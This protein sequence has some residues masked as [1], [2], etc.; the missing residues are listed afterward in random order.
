MKNSIKV[1]MLAIRNLINTKYMIQIVAKF[2]SQ[3]IK[4]LIKHIF[5]IKKI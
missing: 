2:L 1:F 5:I 4:T 3:E